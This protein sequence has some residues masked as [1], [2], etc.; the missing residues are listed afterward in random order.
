MGR[1]SGV[2]QETLLGRE[3]GI[4]GEGVMNIGASDA[5]NY[6]A[7]DI[8][9]RAESYN[10][11]A[12]SNAIAEGSVFDASFVKLRQVVLTFDL[13]NKWFDHDIFQGASIGVVGRNLAILHR[14]TPHIDPETGFSSLNSEQGQEFGQLPSTRSIGFNLNF[15]F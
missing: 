9:V 3:T 13:P 5:P 10:K 12:Y 15:N 4:V 11:A 1:Y 2:L 6:V 8:V 7:N 14:N